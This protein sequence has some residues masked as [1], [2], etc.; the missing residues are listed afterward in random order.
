LPGPNGPGVSLAGGSSL[1]ITRGARHPDDAWALIAFLS[2]PARQADFYERTGDLPAR[3]TAWSTPKLAAD[4]QF[5]AFREQ[6]ARV[7]PMP[8]V[9]E[10]ELIATDIADAAERAARGR[11]TIDAA[12]T[13][14]DAQVDGVL[15]KRRWLLAHRQ[16]LPRASNGTAAK[17]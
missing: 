3:R 15:E 4:P 11:Q 5:A 2:D 12:L 7:A 6:L 17:P 8:A 13:D 10:W 16:T 9:P 1:V 14:L